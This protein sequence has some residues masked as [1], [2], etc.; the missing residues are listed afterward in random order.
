MLE[1][2]IK[3]AQSS[4]TTEWAPLHESTTR[5]SS[6]DAQNTYNAGAEIRPA[7]KPSNYPLDSP[8]WSQKDMQGSVP[9]FPAP[10]SIHHRP[11]S[12]IREDPA[13]LSA[14]PDT[15]Q[16]YYHTPDYSSVNVTTASQMPTPFSMDSLQ[17]PLSSWKDVPQAST[18]SNTQ[19]ATTDTSES[20]HQR[21][22]S[23]VKERDILGSE[24]SRMPLSPEPLIH[25][26]PGS[27]SYEEDRQVKEKVRLRCF[28]PTCPLHVLL[29]PNPPDPLSTIKDQD[30]YLLSLD[31]DQFQKELLSIYWEFQSLSVTVVNKDVFTE[32][33]SHATPSEYYSEFLLNCILACAVRLS[34]RVAIRKLSFLYIKRAKENLVDA[35]EQATIAT[36]Q[37]FCLLSDLEMTS[38]RDQAGWLYAGKPRTGSSV[39][40]RTDIYRYCL[41]LV[42]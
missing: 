20:L 35:L 16:G 8:R 38:G 29:R 9:P 42:I 39:F 33:L 3:E 23:N 15:L 26:R 10:M 36:L 17:R 6:A 21:I 40:F 31:S 12:A 11:T 19:P 28:G 22:T 1:G 34:T 32:H 27:P 24:P 5:A 41:P 2:T 13:P 25:A 18:I 37:G 7:Y 30:R 14:R 4:N